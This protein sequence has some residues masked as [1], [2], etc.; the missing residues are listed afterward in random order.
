MSNKA[1][2]YRAEAAARAKVRAAAKPRTIPNFA[3]GN[4]QYDPSKDRPM[5]GAQL[6]KAQQHMA[7]PTPPASPTDP[8][9]VFK[10]ETIAGLAALKTAVEQGAAASAAATLDETPAPIPTPAID[11]EAA[12]KEKAAGE[13]D[14]KKI[15]SNMDS[16]DLGQALK[17]IEKDV[18]NNTAVRKAVEEKLEDID[19]TAGIS[20]GQ[21]TQV[22]PITDKL[23]VTY[24]SVTPEEDKRIRVILFNM[25]A[26][27][28]RFEYMADDLYG[29][30]LIVASVH[31]INSTEM[32]A[33]MIG[34]THSEVFSEDIFMK[35]FDLFSRYPQPMIH[36]LGVH[37]SWFDQRVRKLFTPASLKNG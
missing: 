30:M 34:T 14:A 35:K 16:L 13:S 31:R 36:A 17:R 12:A 23:S 33:H 9:S 27:E 21:F 1:D 11:R 3:E 2:Q 22:V 20:K 5:T 6:L 4:E 29:L 18:I 8:T 37:G 28:P 24:R 7:D 19:L 15:L 26:E 25:T 32:P 10:P